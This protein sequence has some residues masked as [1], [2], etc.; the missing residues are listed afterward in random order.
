[1]GAA[2]SGT[3]SPYEYLGTVPGV[4]ITPIKEPHYFAPTVSENNRISRFVTHDKSQYLNLYKDVKNQEAI[5]E[6]SASYLWDVQSPKAIHDVVPNARIIMILRDPVERSF[7]HDKNRKFYHL[8]IQSTRTTKGQ[9][10]DTLFLIST[11]S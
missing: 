1:M 7:S 5:G 8:M 6:A 2:R 10:R 11:S 3:T 9:I 4:Y